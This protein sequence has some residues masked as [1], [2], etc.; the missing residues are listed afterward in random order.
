M[1]F[2][3]DAR[4]LAAPQVHADAAR[5]VVQV[6]GL[7]REQRLSGA[8]VPAAEVCVVAPAMAE[9]EGLLDMLVAQP[10]QGATAAV[11]AVDGLQTVTEVAAAHR[12]PAQR[13]R[14]SRTALCVLH[15]DRD[16]TS[17]TPA[18]TRSRATATTP[19]F[20]SDRRRDR[21][22][23]FPWSRR[24][25][26]VASPREGRHVMSPL[27]QP[28]NSTGAHRTPTKG[29][30]MAGEKATAADLGKRSP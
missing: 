22:V 16:R 6:D 20:Y 7:A 24:D 1:P 10:V 28:S 17:V 30:A 8:M 13:D 4:R 27:C 15:S 9:L 18:H 14:G 29:V 11:E 3:V 21:R 23:T 12:S 5:T 19:D 2:P 26:R 25:R